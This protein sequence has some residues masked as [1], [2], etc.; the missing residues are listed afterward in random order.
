MEKVVNILDYIALY[1]EGTP[2]SSI[3]P[4]NNQT[5]NIFKEKE[6]IRV[7]DRNKNYQLL[8]PLKAIEHFTKD[9]KGKSSNYFYM[10]PIRTVK[11]T[12]VGFIF[13]NVFHHDYASV[14]QTFSDSNHKVPFMYGFDTTFKKLENFTKCL[15]LI[16][17][18]S[19]KD[20]IFL[21]KFYPYV[22]ANNTNYLGLNAYIL[23]NLTN[24]YLL[25]YDND[26]GGIEGT[27]N[28]K[29][30]LR[31]LGCIVD[32]IELDEGFKDC[33]DYYNKTAQ[34][35]KLKQ[36]ILNKLRILNSY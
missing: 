18:E 25:V 35:L 33:S 28:D 19:A 8:S 2:L 9:K 30:V 17:C 21:K 10:I 13:R 26:K 22:L 20:C 5:Y 1:E 32:S 7:V 16:I 31:S 23:R 36:K 24:K 6:D 27:K 11:N 12:I 3:K 29:E 34:T 14:Y 15:P 4:L